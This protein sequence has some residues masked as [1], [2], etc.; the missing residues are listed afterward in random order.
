MERDTILVSIY[1]ICYR[2]F[3]ADV[4]FAHLHTTL[5]TEGSMLHIN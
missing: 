4:I 3:F 1:I 2:G 5:R